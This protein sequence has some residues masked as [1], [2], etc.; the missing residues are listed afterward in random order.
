V[1]VELT[2]DDTLHHLHGKLGIPRRLRIGSTVPPT[3]HM[4][5][6]ARYGI[7]D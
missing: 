1:G 4:Q 7:Q 6:A 2:L 5:R 3:T